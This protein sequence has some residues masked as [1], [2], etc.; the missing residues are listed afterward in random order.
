MSS[1][2]QA[3]HAEANSGT[4]NESIPKLIQWYCLQASSFTVGMTFKHIF[5]SALKLHWD[6]VLNATNPEK[7]CDLQDA[8]E[9]SSCIFCASENEPV[10]KYMNLWMRNKSWI[11]QPII[12]LLFLNDGKSLKNCN[13]YGSYNRKHKEKREARASNRWALK[14][15]MGSQ[16]K[17]SCPLKVNFNEDLLFGNVCINYLTEQL[18]SSFSLRASF[19][20]WARHRDQRGPHT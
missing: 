12:L 14:V 7:I 18:Y 8:F 9:H 4:N 15:S 1:W 3:Y 10:E 17:T 16:S 2:Q 19:R 20:T 6:Y 11:N 5:K 13:I